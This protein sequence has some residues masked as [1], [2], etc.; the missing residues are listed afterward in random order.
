MANKVSFYIKVKIQKR[1]NPQ[2]LY[3][4]CSLSFQGQSKNSFM[5]KAP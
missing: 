3:S 5:S 4:T 2:E 1:E